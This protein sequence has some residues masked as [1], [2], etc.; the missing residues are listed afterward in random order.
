MT[1]ILNYKK[2]LDNW[3][4]YWQSYLANNSDVK[5]AGINCKRKSK[6]H[7]IKY[8]IKEGRKVEKDEISLSCILPIIK[9]KNVNYSQNSYENNLNTFLLTD[10]MF[11]EI[12]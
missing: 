11:K 3:D 4:D 1:E 8:G 7:Y 2:Y 12:L 6:N 5:S 9:Y 10:S